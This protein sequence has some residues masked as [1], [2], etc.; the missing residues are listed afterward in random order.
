ME[1]TSEH[2]NTLA[3]PGLLPGKQVKV[4]DTWPVSN[5]I[6]QLL[7][8][9]EGLSTQDLTCKLE[10]VNE[11]R[12]RIAIS[13][14]ATGIELGAFVKLTVQAGYVF[15]L[16]GQCIVRLDWRQK[17]E[18]DQGPASP[19][20]TVETNTS[21]QRTRVSAPE[22]LSDTALVS[23]PDGF[24]TPMHMTQLLYQH[25]GQPNYR[26]HYNREWALTGQTRDHTVFRLMERGDFLVQ[27][28]ITP[29]DRARPG[30]HLSPAEFRMAMS[31]TPGWQQG[32][33]VQEGEI[34]ADK[35]H[36]VY[37]IVAPGDMDGMRVVQN[38]FLVAAASG[39]QVVVVF[40]MAPTQT[41]KI[42]TRDLE[43]VRGIEITK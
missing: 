31:K 14:T 3:L 8:C 29:W 37:R 18:R 42:G 21:L 33:V 13:G 7:C 19:A 38:F 39:E 30:T 28:T 43:F 25:D 22:S 6:A 41:E 1:L 32:E 26:V 17:D 27:A 16:A 10:E 23:V 34:P 12:A 2:F 24:E 9:F 11:G 20:T 4:G 5:D 35:G 40:T 15:D 36:W